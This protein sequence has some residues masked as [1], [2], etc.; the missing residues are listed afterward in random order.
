M[1]APL[2]PEADVIQ[3]AENALHA[4]RA[5]GSQLDPKRRP[6]GGSPTESWFPYY[7]GFS[8]TFAYDV[9]SALPLRK[10]AVVLDPWNGSGTTTVSA[11]ALG[12]RAVG[13]DINP[14]SSLVASARL[15][16]AADA[17]GTQGYRTRL[18]MR[19]ARRRPAEPQNA[20]DPLSEWLTS[21]AVATFRRI[22]ACVLDD[23]ANGNTPIECTPPPLA[24]F[25]LLA[26]MR[27]AKAFAGIRAS[28]N[29]TWVR[30]SGAPQKIGADALFDSW[31][32]LCKQMATDLELTLR[33]SASLTSILYTADSR[34]LPLRDDSVDFV[35]TSPPYC[36]RIDYVVSTSFELAALGIAHTDTKN[37]FGALRRRIM[38]TPLSRGGQT[39][40]SHENL[41]AS[42][43]SLLTS[44]ASHPSKASSTYYLRTYEQY[45]LDASQTLAELKR[46]LRPEASAVMVL[47]TSYYKDIWVDLPGHYCDLARHLGMEAEEIGAVENFRSLTAINTRSQSHREETTYRESIICLHNTGTSCGRT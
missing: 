31:D 42:V 35:L 22:E 16:N 34:S 28:S 27:A 8:S 9:L 36:T 12:Y 20:V 11:A 39:S 13:I 3:D 4:L 25:L 47:Q 14:L 41:P 15:A 33:R 17:L 18:K 44:I 2:S 19:L 45:F 43:R 24:A 29:P 5:I 40:E 23:F 1:N 21:E 37:S 6:Q 30:P 7:A 32:T 38:G 10:D 46:V 26:L